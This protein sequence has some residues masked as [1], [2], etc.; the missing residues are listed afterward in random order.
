MSGGHCLCGA[1]RFT[2]GEAPLWQ[3]HCHCES[4]RRNCAAPFTSYLGLADSS[5]RWTGVAPGVY[6]SSPGV[7]RMFCTTCGTPMAY[8][9]T[10]FPGETHFY[11]ATL[12]DPTDYTPQ[13]HVHWDEHLP[14]LS[15]SDTLPRR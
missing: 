6:V 8:R 3:A 10:E 15:I 7:E 1:V 14:W 4:C 11:A 9:S 2:F 5:W 12:N 13:E